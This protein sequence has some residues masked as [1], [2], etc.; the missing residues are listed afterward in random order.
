MRIIIKNK[1]IIETFKEYFKQKHNLIYI[2]HELNSYGSQSDFKTTR[3][4]AY[5][6]K[7]DF[8]N[9]SSM[10]IDAPEI[11][12]IIADKY[13]TDHKLKLNSIKSD[14]IDF[15]SNADEFDPTHVELTIEYNSGE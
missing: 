14:V 13:Y 6:I 12:E 4:Q 11:Q 10:I 7:F 3:G 15:E 1:Y 8:E 5:D 2:N 9:N